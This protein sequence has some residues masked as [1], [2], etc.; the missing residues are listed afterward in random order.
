MGLGRRQAIGALAITLALAACGKKQDGAQGGPG[1]P[2]GPPPE[3]TVAAPLIKPIVDWDDYVGRFEA[4]K[5]VEIR[6]RVSG[7]L[8][9]QHFRDGQ[10][11]HAGQ[12][13]FTIDP[14]PFQAA[15]DQAK[16]DEARAR[17]AADVARTSFDRTKKLLDL[18]AVSR[19]EFDNAK[20]TLDQA[21]ASL[22]SARA[23][24]E[25]KALDLGYTKVTAPIAGRMSDR[26]LDRGAYVTAGQTVLTTVVQLD[27][28][29]FGF[30][31]SEAVYLKYSRANQAG[32]RPSSRVAPNPV[33]VRLADENVYRWKGYMDFVDNALDLGSGTIRGRAIL[34]NSSNFLTPGMFGHMRLI[35]S[36]SYNGMLIPE[37]AVVTD[38]T[39]KVALVV[40]ADNIV[41]PRVLDLGPI[42]DGLRVV[43]GGLKPDDRVIIAGVQRARPGTKVTVKAGKVVAPAPGTGPSIPPITTTPSSQATFSGGA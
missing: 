16:A 25:A 24:T 30:T 27:P 6:P 5:S 10:F 11:V 31:G 40:G 42:V 8:E 1:G 2:G 20:A 34:R 21:D 14:K 29:Y 26:R 23:A 7:Y 38:Q 3:V 33:E 12:L 43:R 35:G 41:S 17:A 4:V 13:L 37:E 36:G 22:Q 19:E 39:R 9:A 28:I 18:N 32:T 15:Y